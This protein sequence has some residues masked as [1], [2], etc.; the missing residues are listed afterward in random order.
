MRRQ[1][2]DP[3]FRLNVMIYHSEIN[4]ESINGSTIW[5]ISELIDNEPVQTYYYKIPDNYKNDSLIGNLHERYCMYS[6]N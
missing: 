3:S 6:P 4:L 1:R 2:K 5:L